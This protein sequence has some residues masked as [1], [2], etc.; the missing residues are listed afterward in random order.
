MDN[1]T[2]I[3]AQILINTNP[4][5]IN[6]LKTNY[7]GIRATMYNMR[8]NDEKNIR[9]SIDD[10]V[11]LVIGIIFLV[12]AIIV[13]PILHYVYRGSSGNLYVTITITMFVMMVLGLFMVYGWISRA[14][15]S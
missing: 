6:S 1:C 13:Y 15:V 2:S 9:Q 8:V 11:N 4:L 7:G 3:P 10:L 14:L 12:I 5:N